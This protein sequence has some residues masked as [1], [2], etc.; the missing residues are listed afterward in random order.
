[1][2]LV[3]VYGTLKGGFNNNRLLVDQKFLGPALSKGHYKMW[4]VGFPYLAPVAKGGNMVIGE[5][6]EV[7]NAAF[8]NCDRLEGHPRHYKRERHLFV[9]NN[10]TY[11]AWVYLIKANSHQANGARPIE[12]SGIGILRWNGY[13]A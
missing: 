6:Y 5:L 1:M 7:S 11:R 13:N 2:P 3:F 12:P 4:T 8:A 9:C 10:Q